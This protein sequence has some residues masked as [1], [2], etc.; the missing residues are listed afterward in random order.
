MRMICLSKCFLF[1]Y[2]FQICVSVDI[3]GVYR[4]TPWHR[5]HRCMMI[6]IHRGN[7]GGPAG[8]LGWDRAGKF[9]SF[10]KKP[11]GCTGPKWRPQKNHLLGE[12]AT[13]HPTKAMVYVIW[14][15]LVLYIYM[16]QIYIYIQVYATIIYIYTYTYICYMVFICYIIWL[17]LENNG[18]IVGN[19]QT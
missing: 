18:Y 9:P 5:C 4:N 16:L 7:P 8:P 2:Q 12:Y 10:S 13:P 15:H 3:M 1:F 6:D 17:C 19:C 11:M 14:I